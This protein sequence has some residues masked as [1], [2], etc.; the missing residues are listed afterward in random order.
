MTVIEAPIAVPRLVAQNIS[1]F[2]CPACGGALEVNAPESRLGCQGCGHVYAIDDG[3]PRLFWPTESPGA[4]DVTDIVKA[5]YEETPFPNY[6]DL[7]SPE[8]LRA[9]AEQGLFA[10]LLNEEIAHGSRVLE[11][12]CG[13]GQLSN[14]LGLTWGR[15]VFGADVCINSLTLA[16]RF[17]QTHD[18]GGVTFLQMNL[19]RPAFRPETFD[20]VISNG[21]LH[22]TGDPRGGF[23]SILR[24]LRPGGHVIIGLYNTYARLTNDARRLVFR[25]TGDRLTF[26]DPRLRRV[27]LNAGRRRAWFM[28]Q[29]KHPHESKHT[30][31]EVLRW[32]DQS[33]VEFVASI[34]RCVATESFSPT[35]R[36]FAPR[37]RGS[38]FDRLVVQ[39]GMLLSGGRE[40]GFFTMIGRK[41]A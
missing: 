27:A 17:K 8:R 23:V 14:Y 13:T 34:P 9:K 28:D 20:V 33:G 32:F 41:K 15:T 40:G 31:D 4:K 30:F 10:R 3:I 12:G 36:L 37:A 25:L 7:D 29:Y 35:E 22:H 2:M 5:F 6:D 1:M 19:F 11:A 24:C 39:L 18:V 21:V 38:A 16:N 26:L